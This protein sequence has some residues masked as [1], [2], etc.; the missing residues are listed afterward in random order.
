MEQHIQNSERL[1]NYIKQL[2]MCS[3][4]ERNELLGAFKH[5]LGDDYYEAFV[6]LIE[7]ITRMSPENE[8]ASNNAN[9]ALTTSKFNIKCDIDEPLSLNMTNH[10]NVSK[11]AIKM[12]AAEKDSNLATHN[13]NSATSLN[14]SLMELDNSDNWESESGSEIE[15]PSSFKKVKLFSSENVLGLIAKKIQSKDEV[16]ADLEKV[17]DNDE[18]LIDDG[19]SMSLIIPKEEP[20]FDEPSAFPRNI[21]LTG[22]MEVSVANFLAGR[23]YNL[24]KD[25]VS[26]TNRD[27]RDF[28]QKSSKNMISTGKIFDM[29]GR[30]VLQSNQENR[31]GMES[32]QDLLQTLSQSFTIKAEALMPT[33]YRV[34]SSTFRGF[35]PA[36]TIYEL[37]DDEDVI[38]TD[39]NVEFIKYHRPINTES[40]NNDEIEEDL[41]FM[42]G[43][44][45]LWKHRPIKL[46]PQEIILSES[47]VLR[48]GT[49]KTTICLQQ[50][51][52]GNSSQ[53]LIRFL[54]KPAATT[55]SYTLITDLWETKMKFI[56]NKR[57]CTLSE[58]ATRTSK[59]ATHPWL[60]EYQ[61]QKSNVNYSDTTSWSRFKCMGCPFNARDI[62]LFANHL[63]E[64][65]HDSTNFLNCAYCC[66][67]GKMPDEL[68]QH[69]DEHKYDIYQCSHCYYRTA[70]DTNCKTHRELFHSH[71]SANSV[72][73]FKGE[74]ISLKDNLPKIVAAINK[75]VF[76][77]NCFRKYCIS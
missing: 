64:Y 49:Q 25:S 39:G 5:R 23:K 32:Q 59:Y 6:G 40:T 60:P 50:S 67:I 26:N 62:F 45:E 18:Y 55:E 7:T 19:T 75:N 36:M 24:P 1:A 13:Q 48:D 63:K 73:K 76:P 77:I 61:L 11:S 22:H 34:A 29:K 54:K 17:S 30:T 74:Q 71:D 41:V 37:S 43:L 20:T 12:S 46:E 21:I 65:N 42:P 58:N 10:F 69:L 51:G 28:F 16:R 31:V 38:I 35:S 52:Q 4:E 8:F 47:D 14:R 3:D 27:I 72:F 56:A 70:S 15:Y 68:I 44:H 9:N 53:E 57:F 33:V 66:Y 2:Q